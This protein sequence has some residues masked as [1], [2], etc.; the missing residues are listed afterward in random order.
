MLKKVKAPL[1]VDLKKQMEKNVINVT[2]EPRKSV[3]KKTLLDTGTKE[4]DPKSKK[5]VP[6]IK[7]LKQKVGRG[8]KVKSTNKVLETHDTR[9]PKVR[10]QVKS[11]TD[12]AERDI[13]K[14]KHLINLKK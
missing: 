14:I 4:M 9:S 5:M 13:S 2:T 12:R 8:S 6:S 7:K 10:R 3:V 11:I 1:A